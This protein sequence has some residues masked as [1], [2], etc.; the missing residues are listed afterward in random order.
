MVDLSNMDEYVHPGHVTSS[1]LDDAR[2]VTWT[3]AGLLSLGKL[4]LCCAFW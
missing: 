1:D 3:G 4:I 2:H